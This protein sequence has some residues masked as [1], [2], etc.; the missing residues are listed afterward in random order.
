MSEHASAEIEDDVPPRGPRRRYALLILCLAM[1]A[2]AVG[3]GV[4]VGSWPPPDPQP[5]AGPS[6]SAMDPAS[7][8][9]RQ[10]LDLPAG[11]RGRPVAEASAA[12]VAAGGTPVIFDA[13]WNRPV[14]PDWVVCTSEEALRGDESPSGDFDIA[15]VPA[16]DP[17]P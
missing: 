15:A 7:P 14:E 1:L 10:P 13:R 3:L 2:A 17:C 9:P 4:M 11:F 12:A 5:G 16:G 8:T 6:D